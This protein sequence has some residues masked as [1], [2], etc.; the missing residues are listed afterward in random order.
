MRMSARI[1]GGVAAAVA[2]VAAT[3][4]TANPAAA[5]FEP[6]ETGLTFY[7]GGFSTPVAH[8]EDLPDGQCNVMPPTA[9]TLIG[10]SGVT[11]VIGYTGPDCTGYAYGLGNLRNFD[12]GEFQSFVTN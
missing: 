9:D 4:I 8:F 1:T 7:A 2:A 3:L 11:Q 12:A 10:W 6:E 5:A